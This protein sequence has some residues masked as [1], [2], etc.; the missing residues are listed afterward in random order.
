M[1]LEVILLV[2]L[3]CVAI[4]VTAQTELPL[5]ETV[6]MENCS[7][8]YKTDVAVPIY[9]LKG[10]TYELE[11]RTVHIEIGPQEELTWYEGFIKVLIIIVIT[12]SNGKITADF[13]SYL[14]CDLENCDTSSQAAYL[15]WDHAGE[16]RADKAG[17]LF[18]D[19]IPLIVADDSC[20]VT[21]E[22]VSFL[23]V[24]FLVSSFWR[25]FESDSQ[26]LLPLN[27]L[28]LEVEI[29][30][31]RTQEDLVESFQKASE[32]VTAGDAF[33]QEGELDEARSYYEKAKALYDQVNDEVQSNHMKERI[34]QIDYLKASLH[35]DEAEKYFC[36]EEYEKA[37]EEYEKAKIIYD[38]LVDTEES[39]RIQERIA[40]CISY[41]SAVEMLDES[42]RLFEEA[43]TKYGQRWDAFEEAK[44]YFEKAKQ[45]F[46]VLGDSQK[47]SECTTWI[48]RCDEEMSKLTTVK[49]VEVEHPGLSWYG[50]LAIIVLIAGV[51]VIAIVLKRG[52][53]EKVSEVPK[54]ESDLEK[55]KQRLAK[56][57]ITPEEYEKLLSNLEN[58]RKLKYRLVT[59]E[60]TIDEY[61][62]LK[63]QL[64]S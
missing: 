61:E 38:Q 31:S 39:G 11:N 51:L 17:E 30:Y 9:V 52:L 53:A 5:S 46:D 33:S 16:E 50:K 58:M 63:S 12:D 18:T 43:Q 27:G 29:D 14:N 32:Y 25:E 2:L 49:E 44:L 28:T 7:D 36:E 19:R 54:R 62:T 21:V 37:R 48:N 40:L 23:P 13:E 20:E 15:F 56:G 59:G 60:I 45:E 42:I 8:Q 24:W 41:V 22:L 26:C 47:S 10:S 6:E 57:E 55:L 64:D 1:K 34:L 35:V 3:L 4:P